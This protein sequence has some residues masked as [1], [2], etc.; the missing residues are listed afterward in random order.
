MTS[1]KCTNW[2][3]KLKIDKLKEKN[4]AQLKE[5]KSLK[6][7]VKLLKRENNLLVK[8]NIRLNYRKPYEAG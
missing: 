5:I 2:E 3:C 8:G 4:A 7:E 6:A 1:F